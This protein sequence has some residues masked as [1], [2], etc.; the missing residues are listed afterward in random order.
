MSDLLA[1]TFPQEIQWRSAAAGW[2]WLV[3][4][5]DWDT[6]LLGNN[7]V[8]VAS[9]PLIL[10]TGYLP[11]AMQL[12]GEGAVEV[13][14]AA[15]IACPSSVGC[16][17]ISVH[18]VAFMCKR[19]NKSV[20]RMEG[21][22]LSMSNASFVGCSSDTDGSVVQ[23]YDLAT[24]SI[25]ACNFTDVRSGGFGGAVAAIGSNLSISESLMH[26]CSSRRGGGAV[27]ASA[28]PDCFATNEAKNAFLRISS[29]LFSLCSTGGACQIFLC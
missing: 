2:R 24:V 25:Q 7:A 10:C 27:W 5:F 21:S 18:D 8:A 12:R 1:I 19:N 13:S 14:G 16:S 6:V 29:S 20:F 23:A 11:C 3:W 9:S 15:Q 28:Y 17:S 26:N 22:F 4:A